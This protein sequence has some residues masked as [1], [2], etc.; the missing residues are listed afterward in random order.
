M[1]CA[2]ARL[3]NTGKC[4]QAKLLCWWSRTI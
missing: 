1:K 3:K 2:P 4:E